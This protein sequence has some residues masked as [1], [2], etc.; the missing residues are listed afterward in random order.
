MKKR[1]NLLLFLCLAFGLVSALSAQVQTGSVTGQVLDNEGNA[2]PGVNLTI[3]SPNLMGT[4]T[5][6][7][8]ETGAFR[9]PALPPGTYKLTA[10]MQGFKTAEQ[11]R[12]IFAD[13]PGRAHVPFL[14][15]PESLEAIRAWLE[16]IR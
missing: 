5:Y 15:E 1:G 3:A 9:I 11:M 8:S 16:L 2:L 14:D 6:V 10:E 4:R 7:S 12:E 13:V